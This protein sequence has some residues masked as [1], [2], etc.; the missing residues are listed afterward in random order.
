MKQTT[1]YKTKQ[2]TAI[3]QLVKNM[4]DRHFT[5]DSLCAA[6]AESGEP[7]GRTTVYR[8]AEKLSCDGV[9]Q[10]YI[11]PKGESVCYQFVGERGG[12]NE[13]FHLKCEKCGSLIHMD[14]SEMKSLTE[15]IESHHDFCV[16]PLKTVIYGVCK[17]CADK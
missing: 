13:H 16:N 12:C 5:V 1:K 14:C 11:M 3:L 2:K 17:E 10:K 8:F 7:V 15:H 6:L 4:G 9:L